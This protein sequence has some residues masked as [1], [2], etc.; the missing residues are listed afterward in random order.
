MALV[1]LEICFKTPFV[2]SSFHPLLAAEFTFFPM[3][4]LYYTLHLNISINC[5]IQILLF[6]SL[7]CNF[8]QFFMHLF[9][10]YFTYTSVVFCLYPTEVQQRRFGV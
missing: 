9:Q 6:R 5:S 3:I 4:A 1:F 7:Y 8:S 2:R 10:F